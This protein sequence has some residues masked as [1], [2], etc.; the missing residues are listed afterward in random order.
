MF[1]CEGEGV[2]VFALTSVPFEFLSVS[3]CPCTDVPEESCAGAD[4]TGVPAT[5]PPEAAV[6]V[7]VIV[8]VVVVVVP[9]VISGPLLS[10]NAVLD[11]DCGAGGDAIAA[12]AD[13]NDDDDNDDNS[14]PSDCE[15]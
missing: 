11:E 12:L 13:G 1:L 15:C 4:G 3:P 7:V 6:L 10:K 2:Q 5:D 9:G 8:V 14:L